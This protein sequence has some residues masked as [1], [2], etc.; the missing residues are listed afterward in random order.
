MNNHKIFNLNKT[1]NVFIIKN[2]ELF[3]IELK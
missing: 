1:K 3:F 2:K